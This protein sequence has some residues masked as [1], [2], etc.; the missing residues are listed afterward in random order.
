MVKKSIRIKLIKYI[1]A[2]VAV[3]VI[4]STLFLSLL[5]FGHMERERRANLSNQ[6]L[7][8]VL[9][10]EQV[11]AMLVENTQR[12]TENHLVINGMID[13]Q[14]RDTYLPKIVENFASGRDVVSF[15]L[16]DFDGRPLFEKGEHVS[17]LKESD[18]LRMALGMGLPGVFLSQPDHRLI[19]VAPVRYYETTQGAVIVKFDLETICKRLF[20]GEEGM[21]QAFVHGED[22]LHVFNFNS[23]ENY[24]SETVMAGDSAPFLMQLKGGGQVG[25]PTTTFLVPIQKAIGHFIVL[26]LV[27]VVGAVG[28]SMWL[29][30]NIARP[31][32]VLS[33]RVRKVGISGASCCS[34]LGSGDELELLAQ[35][36]DERTR[37]LSTIQ[38]E[39]EYRVAVRTSELKRSE[40]R[41]NKAQSV[42][43]MGSW[44]L[45][46][47]SGRLTWSDEVYRLFD[48]P[49]QTPLD[50]ETFFIQFVYPDDREK[51]AQAWRNALEGLPPYDVEHRIVVSG[52]I[53]W[54]RELAEFV[55]DEQGVVIE[56]NGTVQDITDR[57]E[58]QENI[59]LLSQAMDQSSS[60]IVI[61]DLDGRIIYINPRCM[62]TTGY[63]RDEL[64][65]HNP[66][67][68]QSG[69]TPLSVYQDLWQTISNGQT[70]RG[71]LQNKR[72]D[73]TLFWEYAVITPV[74]NMDGTITHYLAIKDDITE[75]KQLE[76]E[77]QQA[78]AKAEQA[79]RAKSEFLA[80]MSHEIRTPMNAII[81]LS[82]LC[83][84]TQLTAKQKDYI[85]KVHSSATSLLRI[86]NDILDFSKIDAGRLDMESIAFTL[87]ELLGN[88]SSMVSLKAHEKRLEFIMKPALDIPHDLVGDPLRLGQVLLNLASNAVK[89]TQEGEISITI[90]VLHREEGFVRLQFIV[91]DTGIGM[92]EEQI[93]GLFQAFSQADTPFPRRYG[94]TGLGLA[95]S[96]RLIEMMDGSIHVESQPG[97]GS[98]FMFD[99]RLGL[100]KEVARRQFVPANDFAGLKVL[101][102]DDNASTREVIA[103]YLTAFTFDVSQARDGQEAILVLEEGQKQGNPFVLVIMD[104]M[105][106]GQDGV[107]TASLI[108]SNL[109]LTS[110]P[111]IIMTS[112]FGEEQVIRRASEEATIDGFLAKPV[113]QSLL[114]ESIMEVFGKTFQNSVSDSR[115]Q[116]EDRE[117]LA[118]LS[119]AR[120]S[121]VEDNEIN[122]QVARE[123]LEQANIWVVVADHG[124]QAVELVFREPF[125]GVLMDVQMPIMDGLTATREIRKD[126]RFA[127]LPIVAM[128]ANAMSGDRELCLE[129]GMQDHI[130]KPVDPKAMIATLARWIKPSVPQPWPEIIR[131]RDGV[132]KPQPVPEVLP[133]IA[134]I[135]VH[136]G[137]KHLGGQWQSYLE[138]LAKF[139]RNQQGTV[140]A[141]QA[142]LQTRDMETAQRLAHTLKGVAATVGAT[143]MARKAG[144]IESCFRDNQ[145]HDQWDE[146]LAILANE[147]EELC[148][149]IDD[150]L[151]NK[152]D[153]EISVGVAQVDDGESARTIVRQNK[154]LCE[155]FQQLSAFDS[156]V[157]ETLIQLQQLPLPENVAE[158]IQKIADKV[159][160]YDFEA[161][162]IELNQ[163][164]QG[165]G[166]ELEPLHR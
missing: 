97:V 99:V 37:E 72:K 67:L 55:R 109:K 1:S 124:Q 101:V 120:I 107:T 108:R 17:D 105:M 119:G 53:R 50:Y 51:V 25:T 142:A 2:L 122:Q 110:P 31:I 94:G 60:E 149:A 147:L 54:M 35:T 45:G 90:Q 166:L 27:L 75:K 87:D 33:N 70:W 3:T 98:R 58:A 127:R 71:E 64:M 48:I 158:A 19:V 162:A 81:G 118:Q 102:V 47:T 144:Q 154:L 84:Q 114:L 134:G 23:E 139:R 32:I 49:Q 159:S 15:S 56:V 36:F 42:A 86:I 140:Y 30:H 61:T 73:G 92:S 34:P 164:A 112:A 16:V 59:R 133:T 12:L 21:Y 79:S 121:L 143:S 63:S 20:V 126:P 152:P 83:L 129:A 39:L 104:Y 29:G 44:Q 145:H 88:L 96:R 43:R 74:R 153:P 138:L 91:A 9:R 160:L 128:T 157:E 95:I 137:V 163:F 26:G 65:H 111:L 130:A 115:I 89:F 151:P 28:A 82:H 161:A 136:V 141:I 78:L 148:T 69:N 80:N 100:G 77:R 38:K 113:N 22:N 93:S 85:R 10:L 150:A 4:F 131:D 13:P 46:M 8:E 41:L 155:L 156:V 66:S 135:D 123:L 40:S 62:E 11:I 52:T 117:I 6:A 116:S 14:G 76:E 7:H 132:G 24:L 103:F 5:L 106:P 68:V 146:W 18:P 165:I 57:Q 125:D